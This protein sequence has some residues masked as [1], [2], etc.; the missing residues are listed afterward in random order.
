MT[1]AEDLKRYRANLQ[2][3]ID[4]RVVYLALSEA[5]SSAPLAEIYRRL[6]A[7]E[8]KMDGQL[9]WHVTLSDNGCGIP[10]ETLSKVFDPFFSTFGGGTGLGMPISQQYARMLG[11]DLTIESELRRGSLFLFTFE[12][13]ASEIE[14]SA[15]RRQEQERRVIGLA[16][17][18]KVPKVLIVDDVE[19]NRLILN[20]LLKSVG[21][22]TREAVNGRE[23]LTVVADWQPDLILM[24]M[25]MPEMRGDSMIAMID[26][27]PPLAGIP[28]VMV[29]GATDGDL[30]DAGIPEGIPILHK[31]LDFEKLTAEIRKV[32][33]RL[34]M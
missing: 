31:P 17:G 3:E 29:T 27:Y 8:E 15:S 5:E 21:F 11:G 16:P 28:V 7:V 4:A 23:A 32:S 20:A 12:A 24:D 1:T 6:A 9:C 30:I 33:L 14:E 13:E 25:H 34:G 18:Q 22:T 2:G 10:A 26:M 19:S